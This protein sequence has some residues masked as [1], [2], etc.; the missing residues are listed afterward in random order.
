MDKVSI[1]LI[2]AIN[3]AFIGVISFCLF[4]ANTPLPAAA[5][6]NMQ[7]AAMSPS[8]QPGR[9]A[10][11]ADITIT[12]DEVVASGFDLPI[13]VTNAGDGSQRLFVVEQA[14]QIKIIKDGT[15]LATPFL[16]I[17]NLVE[18]CGE[19]GLLGLAFHPDYSTNRFFYVYYTREPD[20]ALAITRYTT[21]SGTPDEADPDSAVPL[22]TIPHPGH[23]NHNGGQLAFSPVNGYLYAGTGDG[24]GAGDPDRN[25]QDKDSLLGKILRLNVTNVATYTIPMD[26]PYVGVAGDDRIWAIGLRN[27]WRFSFDRVTGDLYIGDVG[28]GDWE[29]IDF[30][31][32]GT[33]GGLNFGWRCKEGTSIY[34]PASSQLPCSDSDFLASLTD[35]IAEYDHDLGRSVT[36]GFVYRGGLYPALTGHY[37]Y[38]DYISGRIWSLY[39]TGSTWSTPVEELDAPFNISSFGEDENGELYVVEYDGD[40]GKIRRLADINGSS[41]N[42]LTSQKSASRLGADPGEVVTYTILIRNTGLLTDTP[43]FL[44]DTIPAGLEYVPGSLTATSGSVDASLNPIL[45]WQGTLTPTRNITMTYTVTATGLVTGPLTNQAIL[46]G[47]G[48]EPITLTHTIFVPIP[49]TNYLP[50]IVK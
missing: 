49:F 29:E 43:V 16:S 4:L 25:A 39:Q 32:A 38:A 15:V 41:P 36:G 27:P 31:A 37:F 17:T 26:N 1:K 6:T 42:L 8:L 7:M 48:L 47:S 12:V 10:A 18:C 24:G 3:L 9:L 20:G 21:P 44:T 40:N 34:A 19:R 22:L 13:Q 46:A 28:Q 50:V 45:R 14:G 30:Q 35:P 11:S 33:A 23:A 5:G 2:T